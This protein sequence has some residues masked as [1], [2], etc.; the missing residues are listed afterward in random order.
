[1]LLEDGGC[2]RP[3]FL[4]AWFVEGGEHE[5]RLLTNKCDLQSLTHEWEHGW[6]CARLTILTLNA[7]CGYHHGMAKA[8]LT[9]TKNIHRFARPTTHHKPCCSWSETTPLRDSRSLIP[10]G[11]SCGASISDPLSKSKYLT[12]TVGSAGL[13][14]EER[15]LKSTFL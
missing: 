5:N 10:Q 1:M 4:D 7:C 2:S 11:T 9:H 12:F 6:S 13:V 3:S 15:P 8:L 14:R